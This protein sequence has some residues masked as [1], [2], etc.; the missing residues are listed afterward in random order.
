MAA[1]ISP[2]VGEAD[3]TAQPSTTR[4]FVIRVPSSATKNPEPALTSCL[5]RRSILGDFPADFARTRLI[6]SF[7]F[8]SAVAASSPAVSPWHEPRDWA[9]AV[10]A[11]GLDA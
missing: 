5:P 2:K 6:Y 3:I 8:C 1:D 11:A 9:S 10:L 7:R 4:K